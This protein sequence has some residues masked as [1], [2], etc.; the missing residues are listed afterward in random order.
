MPLHYKYIAFIDFF[1]FGS[2]PLATTCTQGDIRLHGG[3]TAMEGR[4]EIC[5][6]NLWGTICDNN[7][8]LQDAEVAC[9]QLGYTPECKAQTSQAFFMVI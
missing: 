3:A 9:Q 4:V 8:T 6:D 5:H 1:C 2:D 7:W